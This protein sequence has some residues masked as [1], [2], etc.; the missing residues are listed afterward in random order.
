MNDLVVR[1]L[2]IA[3]LTSAIAGVSGCT[4]HES[5]VVATKSD[6]S[7][8]QKARSTRHN[9]DMN[10]PSEPLANSASNV[11]G[12][13]LWTNYEINTAAM[14]IAFDGGNIWVGTEAGVLVYDL[15]NDAVIKKYDNKTGLVSNIVTDIAVDAKGNK[16]VATHGGGLSMFDGKTWT[17]FNVPTIGDPF[18][19]EIVFDRHDNMWVATWNGA[20]MF[21][22]K[23]WKSYFPKDGLV[24]EWVYSIT[25]DK[26]DIVWFGTEAGVS[27]FDGTNWVSYTHEDGLGADLEDIGTYDKLDN[28]SVHHR[29]TEGKEAD[30]YN[31]NYVLSAA[32]DENNVKWFGT[33][34]AGLSRFDGKTWIT[35]TEKDGL[36]GNFVTDI[37]VDG[38]GGIWAATEKGVGILKDGKWL[39]LNEGDGMLGDSVFDIEVDAGGQIWFGTMTGISKLDGFTKVAHAGGGLN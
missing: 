11:F 5:D 4:R 26:D 25:I 8:S 34:G 1:I 14:A 12:H 17:N 23:T 35:Y 30:G 16:W 6:A 27:R 21:D 9:V 10:K 32:T 38:K 37:H 15:V 31:P 28:T 3:F 7:V 36:P 18:V 19:Y 22:G 24:D 13:P 33:W 20:S 29:T 2:V 39:S